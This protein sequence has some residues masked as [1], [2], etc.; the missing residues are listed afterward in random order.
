MEISMIIVSLLLAGSV[1]IPFYL[2]N[3]AGQS[4]RKKFKKKIEEIITKNNLN[5]SESETWGITS[6]GIDP[7]MKKLLFVKIYPTENNIQLVDLS[8]VN[9][10]QI[11]E[12]RKVI[13]TE[14]R[15]ERVLEQL[16]LQ[17]LLKNGNMHILNFYT[18]SE[19]QGEDFEVRRI[20]KWNAL[21]KSFILDK[22]IKQ[23]A[24]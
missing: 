2:F 20:E 12:K 23:K 14:N 16:D 24:A 1:F 19:D 4:E 8:A 15:K 10:F 13:S 17:V 21:L 5:I 22:P 3:I 9:E 11:L 18:I 7:I 6:I